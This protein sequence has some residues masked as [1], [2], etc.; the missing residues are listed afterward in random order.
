VPYDKAKKYRFII[1]PLIKWFVKANMSFAG[2]IG[3]KYSGLSRAECKKHKDEKLIDLCFVILDRFFQGDA[4]YSPDTYEYRVMYGAMSRADAI[5]KTFKISLSKYINGI[6]S[7][8]ELAEPLVHNTRTGCDRE[9][10]IKL[11]NEVTYEKD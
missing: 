1:K 7:L 9:I 10:K 5:M 11:N 2:R 6:D 8:W 4:P 3:R